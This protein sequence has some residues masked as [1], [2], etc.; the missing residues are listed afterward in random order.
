[1]AVVEGASLRRSAAQVGTQL[2]AWSRRLAGAGRM[3]HWRLDSRLPAR[4][5]PAQS[6]RVATRRPARGGHAVGANSQKGAGSSSDEAGGRRR[7]LGQACERQESTAFASRRSR[8]AIGRAGAAE[9]SPNRRSSGEW[10]RKRCSHDRSA[11]RTASYGAR[12]SPLSATWLAEG[13]STAPA[14]RASAQPPLR[15]STARC[16]HPARARV[17][18]AGGPRAGDP[19]QFDS[20]VVL[21]HDR[22]SHRTMRAPSR[23]EHSRRHLPARQQLVTASS[24]GRGWQG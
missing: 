3:R 2:K 1:M 18:T 4:L 7:L 15:S 19:R 20:D 13:F 22:A 21:S 11:Q 12:T 23:R 5:R 9:S 10:T 24:H 16:A 14:G 17:L 8:E 6:R